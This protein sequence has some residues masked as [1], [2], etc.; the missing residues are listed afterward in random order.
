MMVAFL[1]MH[2]L[3]AFPWRNL[4]AGHNTNRPYSHGGS[5]NK[6]LTDNEVCSLAPGSGGRSCTLRLENSFQAGD[7]RA[8]TVV[9][10]ARPRGEDAIALACKVALAILLQRGPHEVW[11]LEKAWR[12]PDSRTFV[13]QLAALLWEDDDGRGLAADSPERDY[14][15]SQVELQLRERGFGGLLDNPLAIG[16][17]RFP[18]A[19][20]PPQPAAGG[21][22]Q[23]PQ[24][25]QPPPATPPQPPQP[26]QPPASPTSGAAAASPLL[27]QR[28]LPAAEQLGVPDRSPPPPPPQPTPLPQPQP[29]QPPQPL[30]SPPPPPV[31]PS[32]PP[33]P[34]CEQQQ[35]PP[36]PRDRRAP[37]IIMCGCGCGGVSIE[38][39]RHARPPVTRPRSRAYRPDPD[40]TSFMRPPGAVR[41]ERIDAVLAELKTQ[42]FDDQMVLEKGCGTKYK[43]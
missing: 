2:K 40:L 18:S 23:P 38:S 1:E 31:L 24:P 42:P 33:C 9:G 19:P 21:M 28:L 15:L 4:F 6:A 27:Q 13:Q 25:P 14:L 36:A 22:Q 34:P 26:P 32:D 29:P 11:L 30:A 39:L 12:H 16:A 3:P 35:P 17:D 43:V 8:L 5:V 37:V 7:G 20:Q 41:Q 10:D